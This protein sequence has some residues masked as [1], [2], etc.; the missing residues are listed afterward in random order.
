MPVGRWLFPLWM[1]LFLHVLCGDVPVQFW[2]I[3]IPC[4]IPHVRSSFLQFLYQDKE[5]FTSTGIQYPFWQNLAWFAEG[6]PSSQNY[7]YSYLPFDGWKFYPFE[8]HPI[9]PQETLKQTTKVPEKWMLRRRS[10]PF[11]WDFLGWYFVRYELF[12]EWQQFSDRH[13]QLHL[14]KAWCRAATDHRSTAT[15]HWS[16]QRE[17]R[18]TQHCPLVKAISTGRFSE[19]MGIHGMLSL[20]ERVDP[21]SCGFFWVSL[22]SLVFC[23]KWWS[24][25]RLKM[26]HAG[27]GTLKKIWET[28]DFHLTSVSSI[29]IGRALEIIRMS[30]FQW[31][32]F[33]FPAMTFWS[34]GAYL[35]HPLTCVWGSKLSIY[36][37]SIES[38]G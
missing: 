24:P 17:A 11:F 20:Y 36:K 16:P 23:W 28:G 15:G 18:L 26:G 8:E 30:V 22:S 10:F 32:F 14:G 33:I 38:I 2:D 12:H 13:L 4:V 19:N 9:L 5:T 3:F 27:V 29:L 34:S 37:L 7:P 31:A 1:Y 6:V 35:H 25:S 21:V